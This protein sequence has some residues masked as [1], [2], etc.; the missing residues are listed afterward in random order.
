MKFYICSI[1]NYIFLSLCLLLLAACQPTSTP[2]STSPTEAATSTPSS[3]QEGVPTT[4]KISKSIFL[5]PAL[6]EDKDSLQ[7][8]QYL[9]EGLVSLDAS[10]KAQPAL[11][12][13][14]VIS[15]DQL[16]YIF[17]LRPGLVFS[18]GTPITPDII[19]ANFNRWFDPENPLHGSDTFPAWKRIFLGFH[20]E[21]DA[22]K[23]AIS[24][25]DG[26]QKVD[27]NTILVHLNRP[28]PD[29]LT[30]LADPAFVVLDIDALS[31][32][33]YGGRDSAIIS[34]GPYIISAWTDEGLTLSPNSKYWG[35]I[36]EAD[37]NFS[38]K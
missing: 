36:P 14:W 4:N 16:D 5:D 38:W 32:G 15:D 23:R 22:D 33:K 9:Y 12:E 6:A 2:I 18:N 17:T 20:N 31:A 19:E 10:G 13:S 37:L 28:V 25:V 34:S 29:L 30:Y 8:T 3:I 21:K 1:R 35:T 11:A 26:I 7:I 27:V 24:T